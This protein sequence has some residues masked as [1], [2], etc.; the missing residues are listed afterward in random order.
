[1]QREYS[2]S[3]F[4]YDLD[5]F[6]QSQ[7]NFYPKNKN[8]QNYLN[9]E[10]DD[11]NLPSAPKI[12]NVKYN[13]YDKISEEPEDKIYIE[14]LNN[15]LNYIGRPYINAND[16]LDDHQFYE[17]TCFEN[18]KKYFA[19]KY[20]MWNFS[21]SEEKTSKEKFINEKNILKCLKHDN[22]LPF[23]ISLKDENYYYILYKKYR[24]ITLKEYLTQKKTLSENEVR[25]IIIELIN[26]LK[27]LRSNNII[28]RNLNLDNILLTDQGEIKVIGFD[29]AIQLKTSQNYIEHEISEFEFIDAPEM[30]Y[31]NNDKHF[32]IFCKYKVNY[33]YEIDIWALGYIMYYL[34]VG[35]APNID[36]NTDM[37]S[38]AKSI[39]NISKRA[40]DCIRRLL[41]PYP[42]KRQKLKQILMLDFFYY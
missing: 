11:N 1:M 15:S 8:K 40:Q 35:K 33:S 7:R 9:T 30:R 42:N 32:N 34:L 29:N 23:L 12:L 6:S 18:K 14:D 20:Y 21:F 17:F 25:F 10:I 39:P 31:T 28:H 38:F 3:N 36:Y 13:N 16:F 5:T 19:K 2:Y 41:E 22:I 37:K 26:L 24:I 4:N 27:Y